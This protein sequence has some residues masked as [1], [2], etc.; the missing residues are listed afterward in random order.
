MLKNQK[1]KAETETEVVAENVVMVVE[2]TEEDAIVVV[3][4]EEDVM[5]AQEEIDVLLEEILETEVIEVIDVIEATEEVL[6][7]QDVLVQILDLEA[8]QVMETE[9]TDEVVLKDQ[10]QDIL[11]AILIRKVHQGQDDQIREVQIDQDVLV[12][13][14]EIQTDQTV[15]TP[16]LTQKV[17]AD[18]DVQDVKSYN[19]NLANLLF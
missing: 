6:I 8:I 15:L 14:R 9:A 5:I 12:L 16:I 17:Q 18:Q 1:T 10:D 13:T 11:K 3:E 2:V 7:D 19:I 4:T